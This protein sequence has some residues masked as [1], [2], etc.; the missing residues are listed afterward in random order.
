[1]ELEDDEDV[2]ETEE[3][4]D[5]LETD[6]DAKHRNRANEPN[7]IAARRETMKPGSDRETMVDA[8]HPEHE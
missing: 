4:Q 1:M 8:A 2:Q 5:E 7:A 6:P 3:E